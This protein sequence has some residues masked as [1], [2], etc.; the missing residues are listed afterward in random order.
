MISCLNEKLWIFIIH[1]HTCFYGLECFWNVHMVN[2]SL[3]IVLLKMCAFYLD[4]SLFLSKLDRWHRQRG[5]SIW[6]H[7]NPWLPY[8]QSD[9]FVF[10]F[11]VNSLRLALIRKFDG[12]GSL[13]SLFDLLV[14]Q[15]EFDEFNV[16]IRIQEQMGEITYLTFNQSNA[17]SNLCEMVYH[18]VTWE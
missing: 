8:L 11:L 18:Q 2:Y 5:L 10:K 13:N 15:F 16:I 17:N 6:L 12:A 14:S 7:I 9:Q 4:K 3:L 1:L